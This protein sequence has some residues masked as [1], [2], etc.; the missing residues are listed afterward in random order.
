MRNCLYSTF[1][2]CLFGFLPASRV[3][4]T[5]ISVEDR[6]KSADSKVM[7]LRDKTLPGFEQR[8]LSAPD[9]DVQIGVFGFNSAS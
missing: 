6:K 4:T 1:A 3:A 9:S 2:S 5:E 8:K 7:Q